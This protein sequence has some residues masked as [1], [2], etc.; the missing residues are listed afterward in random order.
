M[1]HLELPPGKRIA[2]NLGID[3]DAQSLWLG[4]FNMPT[5][6][7]MARGEFGAE[8]AAPRLLALFEKHGIP[9]T[10][11]IPG[12]TLDTFGDIC[13]EVH[14]QGHEVGVH[15]YYHENPT[16][17]GAAAERRLMDMAFDAFS[18]V[19]DVR[20]V[21]Y[22][23]PYWDFSGATG[24]IL[25]DFGFSYSSS[26]M[27]RD[28]VPYRPRQWQVRWEQGNVPG[29]ASRV[30]EIPPNWY[31]SDFVPFATVLGV[32]A[33]Q[34]DTGVALQ[35]WTDIF[36]YGHANVPGGCYA[37]TV[38]P[39][40][41]GQ[42]HLMMV[43]ERLIQYLKSHDDVWFATCEQIAAAWVDDEEDER[44]MGLDDVAGV[45]APPADSGWAA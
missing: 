7:M 24:A 3:F 6:A 22:R 33:G 5:P 30:L 35:R 37:M 18:R 26:L 41:I 36:D 21:G 39:Q 32:Q 1:G 9:T 45:D 31:L 2:V 44:L 25:E 4:G 11:F 42:A 13:R 19:L 40:I 43:Y 14:A 16:M 34:A 8:V 38:H 29:R 17:I 23:S 10:W 15:G 27:G 28:L 20:P 12:H